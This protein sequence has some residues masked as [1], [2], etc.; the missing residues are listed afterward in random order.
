[1]ALTSN[2]R[3]KVWGAL[4]ASRFAPSMSSKLELRAAVDAIDDHL[5][6]AVEK[7]RLNDALP[8]PYKTQATPAQKAVLLAF[9]FLALAIAVIDLTAGR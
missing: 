2:Q 9:E 8:E 6:L 3:E 4:M 7:Q 1:M 5:E